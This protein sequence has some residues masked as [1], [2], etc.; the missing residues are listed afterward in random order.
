MRPEAEAI[1]RFNERADDLIRLV[2]DFEDALGG[3]PHDQRDR[4]EVEEVIDHAPG[5]LEDLHGL[6]HEVETEFDYR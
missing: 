5:V 3:Y 1:A 2:G 6:A 4:A